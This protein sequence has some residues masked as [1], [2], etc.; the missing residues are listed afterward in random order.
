[1]FSSNDSSQLS[2]AA[3][4]EQPLR[5]DEELDP[6][7]IAVDGGRSQRTS[8]GP[9]VSLERLKSSGPKCTDGAV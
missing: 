3:K 2:E 1:M 4:S 9:F 8:S 7:S 6:P 5:F